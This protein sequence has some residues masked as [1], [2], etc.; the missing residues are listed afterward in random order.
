M[1]PRM[2]ARRKAVQ[3]GRMRR[4]LGRL[5][6]VLAVLAVFAGGWWLLKSPVFSV[7]QVVVDG[8]VNA[9]VGEIVDQAGGKVGTPLID[10]DLETIESALGS[11][12]WIE[13]VAV[14]RDWPSTLQVSITERIPAVAIQTLDGVVTVAADAV[15]L[16]G[17]D[18]PGGPFPVLDLR[19]VETADL[20]QDLEVLRAIEF[21]A[22]LGPELSAGTTAGFSSE[23][24]QARVGGF[25]VRVG[26]PERPGEKAE[27][28]RAVLLSAPPPG[29]IITV[30]SPDRPAVLPPEG[31]ET[32][33]RQP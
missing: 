24:L 5:V 28:L 19:G 18:V 1:D 2:A 11:N 17:D 6:K 8:A 13:H 29:S 32:E 15:V 7:S 20:A 14:A 21:L 12:P 16:G 23:G 22:A 31:S 9:P 25:A 3:D 30:I 33:G 26:G 4:S 10:L 27:A